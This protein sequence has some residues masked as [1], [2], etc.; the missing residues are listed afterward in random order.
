V[1]VL[2]VVFRTLWQVANREEPLTFKEGGSGR[3]DR[4]IFGV[5]IAPAGGGKEGVK[6]TRLTTGSGAEKAGLQKGDMVVSVDGVPIKGFQDFVQAIRGRKPGDQLKVTYRR[7][8][9]EVETE[10]TLGSL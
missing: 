9:Q 1:E 2:R 10:V 7:G 3:R 6:I 5:S 8:D 4:G